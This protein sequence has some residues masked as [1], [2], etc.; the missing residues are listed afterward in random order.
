MLFDIRTAA[1]DDLTEQRLQLAASL[2]GAWRMRA[3]ITPWDGTSCH[4]LVAD[5]DDAYGRR[6]MALAARR[7]AFAK[8]G[9]HDRHDVGE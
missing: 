6:A 3:R 8:H 9:V 4:L 5:V 1:L 2:L 7:G